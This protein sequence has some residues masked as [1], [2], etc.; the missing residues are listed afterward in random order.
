[1]YRGMQMSVCAQ[2]HAYRGVCAGVWVYVQCVYRGACVGTEVRVYIQ[3]CVCTGMCVCVQG[4]VNGRVRGQVWFCA[5][6][7][8]CVSAQGSMGGCRGGY[9]GACA[10]RRVRV[11][12]YR[13][14]G[15]EGMQGEQ[16]RVRLSSNNLT[17]ETPFPKPENQ[18]NESCM[19]HLMKGTTTSSCHSSKM[20][21]TPSSRSHGPISFINSE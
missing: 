11:Q 13:L 20:L 9:T 8:L 4:C 5:H 15:R 12:G 1:M 19:S 21:F 7:G 6:I 14:G 3:V 18:F 16:R 17:G 10:Y 2:L